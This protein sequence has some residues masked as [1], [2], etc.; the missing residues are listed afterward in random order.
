MIQFLI[1]FLLMGTGAFAED[2]R[3][4]KPPLYF[5]QNYFFLIIIAAVIVAAGLFL[6]LRF[7]LKKARAKKPGFNAPS[8]PAYQLAFDALDALK[9]KN[10]PAQGKIKEYYIQLSDIVR[11]YIESRFTIRAPEMTTEEFLFKLQE[12]TLLTGNHKNLLKVFLK[13]CDMV[14]FARYGPGVEEIDNSFNAAWRF[15]EETK[16]VVAEPV[17]TKP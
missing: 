17:K 14:K 4:I 7:L 5:P 11:H 8:K 12:A 2:I 16:P 10:L 3:D 13:E 6:L 15:I 9:S 1:I